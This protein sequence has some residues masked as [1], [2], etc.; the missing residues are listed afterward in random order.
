M[1]Q[2][3]L[4]GQEFAPQEG[5]QK[6]SNKI[7]APVYEPKNKKPHILELYDKDK[8]QRLIT[9]IE[10]SDIPDDEK[11]FLIEAARR[12]TVFNYEK[13][14]DYYAHSSKEVQQ[15]MEKSALVIIDFE[16][17]IELGYIRLCDD[18]KNQYLEQYDAE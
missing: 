9:E 8:T 14:A 12:H 15:L 3:N 13:I 2:T 16:K 11:K 4:F 7:Q 17:A 5:E 1:K 10:S 18:I 6:Y